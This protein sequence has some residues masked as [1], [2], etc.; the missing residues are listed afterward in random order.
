MS[1]FHEFIR[2]W[3][4]SLNQDSELQK[5]ITHHKSSIADGQALLELNVKDRGVFSVSLQ[6]KKFQIKPGRAGKP[7]LSWDVPLALF[8]AMVFGN[9]RIL[10][11]LMDQACTLAFDT[12]NFTHWNGTTVLAVILMA[13]EMVKSNPACKKLAENF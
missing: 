13:R 10:Y 7:L 5:L 11:V 12:P 9:E 6:G 4:A 8:K 2:H 3:E 1:V